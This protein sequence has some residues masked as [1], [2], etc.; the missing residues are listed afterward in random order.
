MGLLRLQDNPLVCSAWRARGGK[1]ICPP[2]TR[3]YQCGRHFVETSGAIQVIGA[4]FYNRTRD[5]YREGNPKVDEYVVDAWKSEIDAGRTH[6]GRTLYRKKG[7]M[8]YHGKACV[9]Y[10]EAYLPAT[11]DKLMSDLIVEV[12]RYYPSMTEEEINGINY[13][14]DTRKGAYVDF[15]LNSYHTMCP[16]KLR[17]TTLGKCEVVLD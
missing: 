6:I 16:V 2:G 10:K 11:Y 12:Q 15:H 13:R 4:I 8:Y 3:E 17:P 14:E 7:I 9:E 5:N 1:F